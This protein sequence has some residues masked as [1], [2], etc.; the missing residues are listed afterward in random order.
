MAV[1]RADPPIEFGAIDGNP[2]ELI[3]LLVSP[4]DQTGP[5]IQA[6]QQISR[7]LTDDDFRAAMCAADSAQ[8]VYE[9]IADQEAKAPV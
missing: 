6:L 9:L 4:A 3:F 1:G 2:V 7:I 8:Q 5:H